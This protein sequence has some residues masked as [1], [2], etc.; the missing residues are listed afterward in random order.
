MPPAPLRQ[1][2]RVLSP[3]LE[4]IVSASTGQIPVRAK[5]LIGDGRRIGM[6]VDANGH[7]GVL[8]DLGDRVEIA[9][10]VRAEDGRAAVEVRR[11]AKADDET[12]RRLE[13]LRAPPEQAV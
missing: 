2:I 1:R 6:T 10:I 5:A 3:R 13:H 7:A 8:D 11:V 12:L 4:Q 9:D